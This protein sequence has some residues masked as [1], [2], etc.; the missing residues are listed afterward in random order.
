MLPRTAH[1]STRPF[2]AETYAS[3]GGVLNVTP[4]S[5]STT[6]V[7]GLGRPSRLICLMIATAR[8]TEGFRRVEG[9]AEVGAFVT[10]TR[11]GCIGRSSKCWRL[12]RMKV[13]SF[14]ETR[15]DLENHC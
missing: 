8:V 3:G 10:R 9:L 2:P 13:A 4:S 7:G 6:M 11:G 5:V 1:P 12:A 14:A 15:C